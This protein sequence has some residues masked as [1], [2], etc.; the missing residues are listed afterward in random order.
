MFFTV[1]T[2]AARLDRNHIRGKTAE[3]R[4]T[5]AAKG[6]HGGRCEVIEDDSPVFAHAPKDKGGPVPCTAPSRKPT[7]ESRL[8]QASPGRAV[9]PAC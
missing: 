6:C 2:V 1:L 7:N 5:A 3:G 4:V 9:P 8:R